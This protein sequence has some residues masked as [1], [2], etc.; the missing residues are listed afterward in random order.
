MEETGDIPPFQNSSMHDVEFFSIYFEAGRKLLDFTERPNAEYLNR[1]YEIFKESFNIYFGTYVNSDH[2]YFDGETVKLLKESLYYKIVYVL[3]NSPILSSAVAFHFQNALKE[4]F[5]YLRKLM[6]K[7]KIK[8]CSVGGGAASDVVAVVKILDSLAVKM[9]KKLD[10]RVTIIDSDVNWKSTCFTV[11]KC[12]ENFHT[13]TWKI[14]FVQA[15]ISNKNSYSPDAIKAI[16]EADILLIVMLL[17]EFRNANLD[18]LQTLK[19][20]SEIVQQES[21]LFVLDIALIDYIR[22]CFGISAQIEGYQLI[23]ENLCDFHVLE[24]KAREFFF[25][26]Y[27]MKYFKDL[28]NI[29]CM[30]LCV[31]AWVKTQTKTNSYSR[32]ELQHR[33]NRCIENYNPINSFLKKDAFEA[34]KSASVDRKSKADWSER[35]INEFLNGKELDRICLLTQATQVKE[36]LESA[37]KELISKSRQLKDEEIKIDADAWEIYISQMKQYVLVKKIAYEYFLFG[38]FNRYFL[39]Q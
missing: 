17:Y 3:R 38:K 22:I 24:D 14:S 5:S 28:R 9:D 31:R 32:N 11:L 10:F 18:A 7:E 8:I 25:V 1:Y 23:Y 19:D 13:A 12:L 2:P 15:D 16:Q 6:K 37:K 35:S 20:L 29:Y 26:N 21:M 36:L 27:Y 30:S 34:W 33:F 39:S 4:N